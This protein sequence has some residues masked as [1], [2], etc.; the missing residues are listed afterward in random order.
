M[1]ADLINLA[2]ISWKTNGAA[3]KC[4]KNSDVIVSQI[5]KLVIALKT[6]SN[7]LINSLVIRNECC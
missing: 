5:K 7:E 4:P 6:V 1:N 3:S 2:K